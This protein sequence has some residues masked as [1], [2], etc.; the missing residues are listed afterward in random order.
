MQLTKDALVLRMDLVW[1]GMIDSYVNFTVRA[2][3][4]PSCA[5]IQVEGDTESK[6]M[7]KGIRIPEDFTHESPG[8]FL[9]STQTLYS[10]NLC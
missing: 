5:Q 6:A 10:E 8:I 9:P 3:M 1:P 4:Y 2:Q 7:P